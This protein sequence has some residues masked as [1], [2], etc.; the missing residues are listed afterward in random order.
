MPKGYRCVTCGKWHSE[1]PLDFACLEP[2]YVDELSDAE[3]A[4]RVDDLGDFRVLRQDDAT[5]YFIRGLIEIPIH[6]SKKRFA[7]GVWTS[8]SEESFKKA[9][10]AYRRKREAGPFFGWLSNALPGY[11]STLN[12]KTHVHVRAT[13]RAAIELEPTDHPLAVEQRDGITMTRVKEIVGALLHD[14]A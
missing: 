11:P 10:T 4:E 7:Y 6:R 13:I 8:L 12:L 3:R 2:L 14:S 1:L 5:H 9:R